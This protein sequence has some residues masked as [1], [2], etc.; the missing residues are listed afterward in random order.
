MTLPDVN[1]DY[2][3][4]RFVIR[5][6]HKRASAF[7]LLAVPRA[8]LAFAPGAANLRWRAAGFT[9]VSRRPIAAQRL[10]TA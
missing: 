10:S 7:G 4:V 6:G 5:L 8:I 9:P 3:A 1:P 2:P